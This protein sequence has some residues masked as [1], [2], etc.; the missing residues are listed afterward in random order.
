MKP[1]RVAY[2]RRLIGSRLYYMARI[3]GLMRMLNKTDRALTRSGVKP[4]AAARILGRYLQRIDW[5]EKKMR[6]ESR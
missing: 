3:R 5:Y 2:A 1:E 6:D 4:F